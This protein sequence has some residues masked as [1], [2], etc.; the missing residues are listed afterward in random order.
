MGYSSVWYTTHP[1]LWDGGIVR[2]CVALSFF[3]SIQ[4]FAGVWGT[5]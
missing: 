1:T 4:L 5:S 3:G 2:F